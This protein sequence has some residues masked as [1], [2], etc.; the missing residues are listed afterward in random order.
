MSMRLNNFI[1]GEYY[2]IYNRGNSK[3][4]LF[5]DA[6]DHRYFIKLL[7]VLN[8]N[9]NIRIKRSHGTDKNDDP[10]VSIGAYCLMP[11]HFHILITQEVDGG[12][13]KFMQKVSTGY[14][15]Y[16]NNKYKHTGGLFE[17]KFKSKHVNEDTYLRYLFSYIHLNPLKILNPNWKSRVKT[18]SKEMFSYL[19]KYEYSSFNEYLTGRFIVVNKR[20]FPDYFPTKQTFIKSITSWFDQ[21]ILE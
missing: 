8:T 17:G 18:M 13:S 5:H 16:Y 3:R 10:L 12:V 19:S 1:E 9:Y 7:T 14:V 2:H 21:N 20:V 15:M 4:V 6:Q 11:N